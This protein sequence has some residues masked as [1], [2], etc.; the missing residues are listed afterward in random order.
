MNVDDLLKALKGYTTFKTVEEI[1]S[2]MPEISRNEVRGALSRAKKNRY[3]NHQYGSYAI[4]SVGRQ[5]LANLFKETDYGFYGNV[6][7][8]R[9]KFV[10][11]IWNRGREGDC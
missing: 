11:E 2:L 8:A 5:Y 10:L 9:R 7:P 1:H 4:S 3:L 6:D